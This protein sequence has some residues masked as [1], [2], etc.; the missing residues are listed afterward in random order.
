MGGERFTTVVFRSDIKRLKS[1][2]SPGKRVAEFASGI[3]FVCCGK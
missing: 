3:S 1:N 2:A